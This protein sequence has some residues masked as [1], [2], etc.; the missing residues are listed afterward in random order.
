MDFEYSIKGLDVINQS[1]E[2][3]SSQNEGDNY[4]DECDKIS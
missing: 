1:E 3:W 2:R 4:T